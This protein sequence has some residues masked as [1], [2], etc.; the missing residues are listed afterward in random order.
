MTGCSDIDN[1]WDIAESIKTC[2]L[3]TVASGRMRAR[4]MHALPDRDRGCLWFITDCC[5]D[6]SRAS[7]GLLREASPALGG[8][9]AIADDISDLRNDIA[10]TEDVRTIVN[11]EIG[12]IL[13]ELSVRPKTS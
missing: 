7:E 1:V 13:S 4:P 11:E 3:T 12:P 10:T 2:M 6:D 5:Y 8:F 9:K